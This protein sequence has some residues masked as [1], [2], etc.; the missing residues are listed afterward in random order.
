MRQ[1]PARLISCGAM[2]RRA[3]SFLSAPRPSVKL[4]KMVLDVGSLALLATLTALALAAPLSAGDAQAPFAAADGATAWTLDRF[5]SLVTFGDSFT[6]ESR[7]PYF[8]EHGRAPPAGWM[9]PVVRPLDRRRWTTAHT[10]AEQTDRRRGPRLAALGQ[11]VHGR[12]HVQLRRQRGPVLD[13]H[14]AAQRWLPGHQGVRGGRVRER[15]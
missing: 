13:R 15:P 14:H 4:L 8:G 9:G 5:K 12:Q 6:D 7:A 10:Y 3:T 11:L 1:G 2:I